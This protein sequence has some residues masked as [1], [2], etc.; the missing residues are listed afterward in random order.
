MQKRNCSTELPLRCCQL[1]KASSSVFGFQPSHAPDACKR[2]ELFH[3][4][5]AFK[6]HTSVVIRS[7]QLDGSVKSD[8]MDLSHDSLLLAGSSDTARAQA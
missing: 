1:S 4:S 5:N 3:L 6:S 8:E 2:A 7:L